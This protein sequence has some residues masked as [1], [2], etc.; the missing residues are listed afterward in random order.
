MPAQPERILQQ[1]CQVFVAGQSGSAVR[2]H[3]N[4]GKNRLTRKAPRHYSV[5]ARNFRHSSPV[6]ERA[7]TVEQLL[8]RLTCF[9]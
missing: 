9:G 1:R 7:A 8:E 5:S 2:C 3:V 6:N 4:E